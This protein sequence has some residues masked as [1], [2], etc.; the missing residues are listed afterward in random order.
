MLAQFKDWKRIWRALQK[1]HLMQYV[2]MMVFCLI[3]LST[4]EQIFKKYGHTNITFTKISKKSIN[5]YIQLILARP[6]IR[7][8]Q[9]P[10][11]LSRDAWVDARKGSLGTSESKW[12][13][14]DDR[15]FVVQSRHHRP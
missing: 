2:V 6:S 13:H 8:F 1:A 3:T 9:N 14:S 12:R 11:F 4:L 7:I 15:H 10:V 5:K